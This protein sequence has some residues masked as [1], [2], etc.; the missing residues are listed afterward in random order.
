MARV[1]ARGKLVCRISFKLCLAARLCTVVHNV[2]LRVGSGRLAPH[3]LN[4]SR[5]LPPGL[6]VGVKWRGAAP[7]PSRSCQLCSQEEIA[8]RPG[9]AASKLR[10]RPGGQRAAGMGPQEGP[11]L[12]NMRGWF[13][14]GFPLYFGLGAALKL[15]APPHVLQC[16]K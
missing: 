6:R 15:A 8:A 12:L 10:I 13:R 7:Y 16:A 14:A 1:R 5:G 11:H 3:L 2:K 9:R 4:K